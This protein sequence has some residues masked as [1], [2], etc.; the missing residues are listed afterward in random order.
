MPIF[1]PTPIG[2]GCSSAG[3]G[4]LHIWADIGW[5]EEEWIDGDAGEVCEY[6]VCDGV[7]VREVV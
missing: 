3:W 7:S 6:V 1:T 4:F 2:V 5:C